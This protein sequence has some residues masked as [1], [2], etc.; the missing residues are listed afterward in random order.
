[1]VSAK[2]LPLIGAALVLIIPN[3]VALWG[4]FIQSKRQTKS[5]LLISRINFLSQQ[6][7][8]FYDSLF[9][10]L[11][12]TGIIHFLINSGVVNT[13]QTCDGRTLISTTFLNIFRP[14]E[15]APLSI[16]SPLVVFKSQTTFLAAI[17][18][19]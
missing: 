1:M 11:K 18:K 17:I 13:C 2:V 4:I 8:E 12:V 3:A 14:V 7:A 15:R 9:A 16:F 5:Q 6:L 10:M 19:S